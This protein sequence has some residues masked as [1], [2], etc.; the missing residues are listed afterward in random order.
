MRVLGP[1]C[2]LMEKTEATKKVNEK[3]EENLEKLTEL[4]L[5]IPLNLPVKKMLTFSDAGDYLLTNAHMAYFSNY[6]ELSNSI[7]SFIKLLKFGYSKAGI[8]A[9]K[10]SNPERD[11]FYYHECCIRI[12]ES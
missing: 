1:F 10:D 2:A 12:T 7:T 8:P 11:S 3:V 9:I 4:V 6:A 5:S